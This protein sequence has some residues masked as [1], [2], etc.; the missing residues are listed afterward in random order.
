MST[1]Q[2][3]ML[4]LARPGGFRIRMLSSRERFK[5]GMSGQ[6]QSLG[7]SGRS[8]GPVLRQLPSPGIVCQSDNT[9]LQTSNP[10]RF[11]SEFLEGV[12]SSQRRTIDNY[13]KDRD[14]DRALIEQ[15]KIDN[16]KVASRLKKQGDYDE[17][18]AKT[19]LGYDAGFEA[20]ILK[21]NICRPC[22][23]TNSTTE[24]RF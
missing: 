10:S 19:M 7:K 2:S 17:L 20:G 9:A 5:Q 1:G 6:V 22:N 12:I 4:E 14:N 16:E 21:V 8:S 15:L 13:Q 23:L 3:R 24:I 11:S 18:K